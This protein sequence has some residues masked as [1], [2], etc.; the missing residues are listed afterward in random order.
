MHVART[1]LH[2]RILPQKRSV[3]FEVGS[4]VYIQLETHKFQELCRDMTSKDP[5]V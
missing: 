5:I 2:I 3:P 1:V 4:L